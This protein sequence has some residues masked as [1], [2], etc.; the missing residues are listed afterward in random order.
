MIVLVCGGHAYRDREYV[1]RKLDDTRAAYG[2]SLL[3]NGGA[4]C[5]DTFAA[6]WAYAHGVPVFTERADWK[7]YG[8]YAGHIR[9]AKML[10]DWNPRLVIA[11]PGGPGTASMRIKAFLAGV[12]VLRFDG[13]K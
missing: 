10:E 11:F 7:R 5:T 8:A 13:V 1:W 4:D 3:V 2:F 12:P 6:E 9:N